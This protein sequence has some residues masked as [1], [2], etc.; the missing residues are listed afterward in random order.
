MTN[1]QRQT[2]YRQRQRVASIS[3]TVTKIAIRRIKCLPAAR[4][5]EI[6]VTHEEIEANFAML[7]RDQ[8]RGTTADL[9]DFAVAYWD[10]ERVH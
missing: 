4:G 6:S 3:V 2:A 8:P 7:L 9:I 10:G 1:A 5:R